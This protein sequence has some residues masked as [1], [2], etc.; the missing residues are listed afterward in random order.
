MGHDGIATGGHPRH[1]QTA[2][3]LLEYAPIKNSARQRDTQASEPG[4][5]SADLDVGFTM[6]ESGS[7]QV[8]SCQ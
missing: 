5:M 7:E 3:S 6:Q 4:I 8:T 2:P 1:L